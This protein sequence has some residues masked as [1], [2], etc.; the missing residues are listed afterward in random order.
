MP[1]ISV[2]IPVYN[3][4]NYLEK[5]LNSVIAQTFTELD[6]ILVD[7]GSTDSSGAVCDRYAKLDTRIRVVHTE[8]CGLSVARNTGLSLATGSYIG[9]V[10]SDDWI[11]PDMFAMLYSTLIQHDADI[12]QCGYSIEENGVITKNFND[13]GS[14]EIFSP[15]EALRLLIED[16]HI[17][18]FAWNKLY[19]KHLFDAIQFPLLRYLED[20]AIMYALF[21]KAQ[22]V[23]S[24]NLP[25]YIYVRHTASLTAMLSPLKKYHSFCAYSMRH[26]YV[27]K[28]FPELVHYHTSLVWRSAMYAANS[29]VVNAAHFNEYKNEYTE[30]V[31]LIRNYA[32]DIAK[33]K[34]VS[35][36]NKAYCRAIV[37]GKWVHT[38]VVR[39]KVYD[40]FFTMGRV[41]TR[42]ITL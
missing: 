22:R 27:M 8:N 37:R 1:I 21:D 38:L 24:I 18:N 41:F 35:R 9:F 20:L 12:V 10:D 42:K 25:Y 4:D 13:D 33:S 30:L 31:A 23:V 6:I 11:K 40:L 32:L 7:D 39:T 14:I 5:C 2:I 3:V 19:K 28:H 16:V 15:K 29:F 26:P 34:H 36:K 17:R